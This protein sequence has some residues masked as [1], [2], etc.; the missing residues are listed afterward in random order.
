MIVDW[1]SWGAVLFDLD[2][3]ITPTHDIHAR[4]WA[5]LFAP[6]GFTEADYLAYVDGRPRYDGVHA[7]LSARG[8]DLPWGDPSD[9][10]GTGTVCA[11][12]N[13][14]NEMFNEILRRD[15]ITPYPG[16]VAV[17]DVLVAAAVPM[18]IVSSSRNAGPVLEAAGLGD[19]F[20]VVV[21]GLTAV[22]ADLPGKP[23]P[24]MFAHAAHMLGVPAE[25]CVVVEDAVSGVRA[26]A[27][28][29]FGLVIGVDRTYPPGGNAPALKA[30][31]A[32]AVVTDLADTLAD[33][34][35]R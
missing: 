24:A 14:K 8:V 1:T 29:G 30:A 21:D 10:P 23:D 16:T 4:A 19:R 32:T 34:G 12:G 17:I 2:G 31:G 18:A 22:E 27:A 25:R 33:R 13:R 28:G 9:A 26:G 15:R 6:W 3:V 11:M 35:T 5:E 20:E 7:F